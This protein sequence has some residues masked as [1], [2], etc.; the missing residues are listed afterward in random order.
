MGTSTKRIS[1][2]PSARSNSSAMS[3]GVVHRAR[4]LASVTLVVSNVP[5]AAAT[6]AG[7]RNGTAKALVHAMVVSTRRRV[8]DIAYLPVLNTGLHGFRLFMITS[9]CG[10]SD[11]RNKGGVIRVIDRFPR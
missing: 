4:F 11:Q 8:I 6:R 10:F 3:C 5:S 1:V 7:R 2:K 9:V